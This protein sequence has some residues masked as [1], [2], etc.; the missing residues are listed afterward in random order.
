V[1]GHSRVNLVLQAC[2]SV[3]TT[4]VQPHLAEV[5]QRYGLPPRINADHGAP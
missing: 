1:D 3:A 4:S 5:F 2:P